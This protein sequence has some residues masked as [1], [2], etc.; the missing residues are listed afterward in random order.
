MVLV[1]EMQIYNLSIGTPATVQAVALP[2][3]T[4][5]GKVSLIAEAPTIQSNVVNYQVTVQMDP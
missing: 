1:S 3:Y 4:F 2:S 5:P